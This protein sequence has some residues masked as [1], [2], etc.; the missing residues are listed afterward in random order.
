MKMLLAGF[1]ICASLAPCLVQASAKGD[2]SSSKFLEEPRWSLE[3]QP[4]FATLA[5]FQEPKVS[6]PESSWN[7]TLSADWN[8]AAPLPE[9]TYGTSHQWN[10]ET[11]RPGAPWEW[12]RWNFGDD[13]GLGGLTGDDG[14]HDHHHHH[15]PAVPEASSWILLALGLAAV[16]V[17]K[18]KRSWRI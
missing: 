7:F 15:V 5:A 2:T 14:G 6:A 17:V 12:A 8:P 4:S 1:A 18:V 13:D 11:F 16:T 10:P 9:P 3:R